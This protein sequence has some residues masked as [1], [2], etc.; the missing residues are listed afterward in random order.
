MCRKTCWKGHDG[1]NVSKWNLEV[2][3]FDAQW[4][5]QKE[6]DMCMLGVVEGHMLPWG[7]VGKGRCCCRPM[8]GLQ[9]GR[10]IDQPWMINDKSSGYDWCYK[11]P[12]L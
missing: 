9:K 11:G 2:E 1:A 5:V 3:P 8:L 6:E 12:I 7:I 10:E 4:I